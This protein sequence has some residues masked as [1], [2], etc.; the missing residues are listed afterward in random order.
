MVEEK[1]C[2]RV[3][4]LDECR[5]AIVAAAIRAPSAENTQPWR[6]RWDRESL[7][8]HL[9]TTRTLASDVD[10]MLGLTAI[11]AC[12]ENV[13]LA[14]TRYGLKSDVEILRTNRIRSNS[15]E[16]PIASIR[17]VEGAEQDPLAE[18]IDSRCTC[19]RMD[20]RKVVASSLL[21]KL[22]RSGEQFH[23][24]AVHWVDQDRLPEFATFVGIGNRM[25]F[26]HEPFHKEFYDNLRTTGA[27][28]AQ[29][30]DGLDVATLQLPPGV[31]WILSALRT[32]PRTQWANLFGFS[33]TVA[34]QTRREVLHSG[35]V[36]FLTVA[37]PEAEHFIHGGRA[38]ERIWLAAARGGLLLHP[39]ASL[40]VVL[41]HARLGYRQLSPQHQRVAAKMNEEFCQLFPEVTSRILQI[42][43]RIGY[44]H[45]PKVRSLRRSMKVVVKVN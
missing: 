10:H 29:T 2:T 44:G 37:A 17:F 40:P 22:E 15:P 1:V 14:A 38:F 18:F 42:A 31:T 23:D 13:V 45:Q 20:G 6:F 4:A 41:T 16:N 43:F 5:E 28:A 3:A 26:E 7:V 33:R 25:R 34:R 8:V 39:A 19:R 12:I 11:G 32:W 30:R 9:D 36:G 35:A 24:V 27:E 21:A